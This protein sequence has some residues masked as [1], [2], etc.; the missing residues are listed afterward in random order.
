MAAAAVAKKEAGKSLFEGWEEG[1]PAAE[2]VV[3]SG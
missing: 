1:L 3:G 2:L